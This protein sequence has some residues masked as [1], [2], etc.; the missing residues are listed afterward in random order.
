[1]VVGLVV[2]VIVV[3]LVVVVEGGSGGLMK[4]DLIVIDLLCF[5]AFT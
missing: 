1:L 2:V 5:D 3:V 4:V